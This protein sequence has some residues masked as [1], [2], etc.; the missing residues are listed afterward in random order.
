LLALEANRGSAA[1]RPLR[2]VLIEPVPVIREGLVMFLGTQQD[3]ASVEPVAGVAEG[4]SAAMRLPEPAHVL[5]LLELDSD[6]DP[7]AAV[8]RL[9]RRLPKATIVATAIVASRRTISQVIAEGADGY[10]AKR[11][12]PVEFV[13]ALRRTAAGETVIAGMPPELA[14]ALEDGS[15]LVP[16]LTPRQT[17]V[18]GL[19]GEGLT[20]R[21]IGVRLGLSE[22]T[23]SSHLVRIYRRLGVSGRVHALRFAARHDLLPD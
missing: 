12:D 3:F 9:R 22:R 2:V 6:E 1:Q 23:V 20:D 7:V 17:T 10:V 8:R 19:A 5:I 16:S 13:D 14:P 21:E 18:L 11:A 4:L 15:D